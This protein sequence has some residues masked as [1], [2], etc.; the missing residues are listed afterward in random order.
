MAGLTVSLA[1]IDQT[2]ECVGYELFAY[3]GRS[4]SVDVVEYAA[5]GRPELLVPVGTGP[6]HGKTS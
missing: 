1:G 3:G 4:G 5:M 6:L 2:L